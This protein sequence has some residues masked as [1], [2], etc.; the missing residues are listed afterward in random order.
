MTCKIVVLVGLGMLLFVSPANAI[1][2]GSN[3]G[4]GHPY[5]GGIDARPAGGGIFTAS[6]VLV[7]STVLVTA[8]HGTLRFEAAGLTRARVTFD[9]VASDSGTWYTGTVH[10]NPAYDPQSA[11]DPGDLG[12]VVFDAPIPGI[13]PAS[14][15]AE[16][17][18][19]QL[20]PPGMNRGGTDVVAYG[21]SSYLAGTRRP[22]PGSTGTRRIARQTATSLT[23]GWLR[24]RM[25]EG[26]EICTGDSGSPSL[27]GSSHVV[28]GITTGETSLSGGRCTSQPWDSRLDTPAARAFLGQYVTLPSHDAPWR[29]VR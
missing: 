7:S 6:G 17:Q 5:V 1:I 15:P 28:A 3:D 16:G 27:L 29:H 26:A 21:I 8:G 2:G 9:P 10:T 24:L 12:V 18:L 20:G 23:P 4:G 25:N 22:D 11:D 19:A 14:L 13:A